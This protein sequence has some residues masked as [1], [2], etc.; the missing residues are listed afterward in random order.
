MVELDDLAGKVFALLKGNGL[1]IKIFDEAGAETTDPNTGRRF[2]VMNPNIM[3]TLDEENNKIEFSKGAE[4][5]DDVVGIQKNIRK[6]ADEFLM[7]SDI[8][9]F[10]KQIQPRDYAYQAKMQKGAA[11][12][13]N[14]MKPINHLLAGQILNSFKHQGTA[15]AETIANN[16]GITLAEV[17][18]VLNKLVS[19][20]K[21]KA[22]TGRTGTVMYSIAIDEA[23]T[24]S[25]SR[26]FGSLK[27]SQQTLE[28]VRIL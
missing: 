28:N 14:E 1:K 21:V 25:F 16:L 6:L 24:E 18:P 12:M 15:Y 5:G 13:E 26:M 20:G 9:V 7:N 17:Q 27:T 23:I 2:F 8:K 11:M 4:T 3:V 19:D 22:R 10:G